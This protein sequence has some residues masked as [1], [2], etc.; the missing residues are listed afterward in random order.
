MVNNNLG[1]YGRTNSSYLI[2]AV[3][4]P[5][6]GST[7]RVA[8]YNVAN[9]QPQ[10]NQSVGS[11][12]YAQ[13]SNGGYG[14]GGGGGAPQ[15]KANKP[16]NA[17][18]GGQGGNGLVCLYAN[19]TLIND[20][21]SLSGNPVSPLPIVPNIND[22]NNPVTTF[23]I[24]S[25][26]GT[27]TYDNSSYPNNQGASTSGI[28]YNSLTYYTIFLGPGTFT[29]ETNLP[30][31]YVSMTGGGG[32]G[33]GGCSLYNY[34]SYYGSGGGG[35]AAVI[36]GTLYL[37]ECGFNNFTGL[38]S[39]IQITVGSGGSGG[40]GGTPS[41]VLGTSGSSG[42]SSTVSITNSLLS[43]PIV[44]TTGAGSGGNPPC[45]N[46]GEVEPI[47]C[48]GTGGNQGIYS[49]SGLSQTGINALYL[50]D[51]GNG[52]VGSPGG[53][54]AAAANGSSITSSSQQA[55]EIP[56]FNNGDSAAVVNL[57]GG[58]GGSDANDGGKGTFGGAGAGGNGGSVDNNA[59]SS[60]SLSIWSIL[61]SEPVNVLTGLVTFSDVF[62]LTFVSA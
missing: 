52:G 17:Y 14:G 62:K 1:T 41:S 21:G 31:I 16:G 56:Y 53:V 58:G 11:T 24:I 40:Q 13:Y 4:S 2:G 18:S 9:P 5:G 61:T 7:K 55:Y 37:Y 59:P 49:Y 33:A 34:Y 3:S 12:P 19:T 48:I 36:S 51:G 30:V 43:S 20:T 29:I 50:F 44:L 23:N 15:Y 42:T 45:T 47:T 60:Q 57:G 10:V 6:A 28:S 38:T 25:A 8:Q 35:G 26:T 54:N 27:I 39:T 22:E 46:R 32:G